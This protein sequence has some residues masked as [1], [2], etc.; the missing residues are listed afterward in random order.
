MGEIT[1]FALLEK[2]KELNVDPQI[3][4]VHQSI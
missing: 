4:F 2:M 1:D 3:F